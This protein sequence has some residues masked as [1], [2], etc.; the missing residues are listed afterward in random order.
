MRLGFAPTLLAP[1]RD[2]VE[3]YDLLSKL[4]PAV[5]IDA[6]NSEDMFW[7]INRPRKSKVQPTAPLKATEIGRAVALS[8]AG[9]ELPSD[10]LHKDVLEKMLRD[11]RAKIDW[12][13]GN[14][15][16][17]LR[18]LN[19]GNRLNYSNRFQKPEPNGYF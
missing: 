19:S 12:F 4:L 17:A 10:C 13:S 7:Q 9:G 1:V 8:I 18:H 5:R 14:E 16:I 3:G 6:A 11:K 15:P 2:R